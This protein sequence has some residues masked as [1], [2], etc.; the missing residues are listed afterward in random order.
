MCG[1]RV[2]VGETGHLWDGEVGV[3]KED[4][5]LDGVGSGCAL[6]DRSAGCG[7]CRGGRDRG[8]LL[9]VPRLELLKRELVVPILVCFLEGLF[10]CGFC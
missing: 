1:V 5:L 6:L 9:L 8:A 10:G 3:L 4:L 7:R 2:Q